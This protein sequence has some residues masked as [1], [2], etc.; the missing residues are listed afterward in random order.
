MYKRVI[1]AAR[2]EGPVPAWKGGLDMRRSDVLLLFFV[3]LLTIMLWLELLPVVY[4]LILTFILL[5]C[6][7]LFYSSL[8]GQAWTT[9]T[10]LILFGLLSLYQVHYLAYNSTFHFGEGVSFDPV[11]GIV[12]MVVIWMVATSVELLH[13]A[14]YLLKKIASSRNPAIH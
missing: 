13:W 1:Q 6:G 9:A 2:A 14:Y 7:S 11:T 10:L 5:M 8:K 12:L 4:V 3:S